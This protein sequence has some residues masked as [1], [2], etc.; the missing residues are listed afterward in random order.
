MEAGVE[1]H[2]FVDQLI[3]LLVTVGAAAVTDAA[4]ASIPASGAVVVLART[5]VGVR[6]AIFMFFEKVAG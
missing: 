1:G 2:D 5:S 4:A 3:H 6:P